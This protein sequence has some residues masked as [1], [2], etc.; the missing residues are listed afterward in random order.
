MLPLLRSRRPMSF[1]S[2]LKTDFQ[3]LISDDT[4]PPELRERKARE[5][6]VLRAQLNRSKFVDA[7]TAAT[8]K[9]SLSSEALSPP[10]PEARFPDL[11][12]LHVAPAPGS[13]AA[14]DTRSLL[15]ASSGG[16]GAAAATLV[17]LAFQGRGQAQL[18]PWHGALLEAR[19][20]GAAGGLQLLNIVLLQGWLWRATAGLVAG[21]TRRALHPAVAC[22]THLSVH[23]SAME[24]D[25]IADRLGVHNRMLA[26]VFLCDGAGVVRWRAHGE[27]GEGEADAM[28][29]AAE[30]LVK[31]GG[32][33]KRG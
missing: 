25:H 22:D 30:A 28:L 32:E 31:V 9:R 7:A 8:D 12:L 20:R 16:S 10:L 27:P 14:S 23:G 17:T 6:R 19:E 24:V 15:R 21:G 33:R 26:W 13:A 1:F 3:S 18:P 4:L 11:P 5:S 29:R 2:K